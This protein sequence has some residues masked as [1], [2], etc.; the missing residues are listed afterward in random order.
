MSRIAHPRSNTRPK[1]IQAGTFHPTDNPA[2]NTK[3]LEAGVDLGKETFDASVNGTARTWPNTAA[4]ISMFL[5]HLLSL[6]RPVRVSCE[7]TGGYTRK[8]VV[9]CLHQG[10]PI[11]L[12]NARSVRAF[13]RATGCLAKT[14]R[15]DAGIIARHAATFD[16]PVL[17]PSWEREERLR[18]F[19]QRLDALI[20]ARARRRT[21]LEYYDDPEIRAEIK[22]E[23]AALG[24]RIESYQARIDH[25][26]TEDA[27]LARKRGIMRQTIGV[28]PVVSTTLVVTFPE[29]G[30]LNRK[31]AA[32]LA[33][34]APMNRDSG[35]ARGR[36]TIQ[37]GRSKP[38]KALYMAALT[39]AHRNPMFAP[40]YQQLIARGKPVKV[41]LCAIARKLL[42]HLNT[43]L[44]AEPQKT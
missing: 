23:I 21:S 29:L 28:G 22:R 25:H 3:P 38:R 36:R 31:Q 12:L 32:A 8:L 27:E 13:A 43:Q 33:G 24:K 5:K 2:M 11:A 41:A 15:I 37:A 14:D 19:H 42:V 44:K 39:A 18:Q 4:G 16:P 20:D 9:A 7:A 34:L 40:Q 17:D 26:I 30:T 10:V 6:G 35:A 1:D